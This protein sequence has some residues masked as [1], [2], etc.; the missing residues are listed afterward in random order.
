MDVEV[1]QVDETEIPLEDREG[2]TPTGGRGDV[3][4]T[5]QE[6]LSSVFNATSTDAD[7]ALFISRLRSRL[8]KCFK[9]F[10]VPVAKQRRLRILSEV[11]GIIKP[12]RMTLVLG[13]SGSGK[14]TFLL[15]LSGQLSPCLKVSG[16]VGY[17]GYEFHECEPR[18]NAA[19]VSQQDLHVGEMTVRE[20]FLYSARSQGFG[21][22]SVQMDLLEKENEMGI[23][24]HPEVHKYMEARVAPGVADHLLTGYALKILGLESCA[25][26]L[27]GD[28]VQHG[29]SED[30]KRSVTTGEMLVGP[31]RT[32]FMD[33]TS[34]G[35]DSSTT[36]Q[37]VACFRNLCHSL[38]NTV[39][40]SLLRPSPETFSLFDDII[41]LSEG[42]VL[43]HGDRADVLEFFEDCGFKCPERKPIA[44]FLLE[45]TSPK[46]QEQYWVNKQQLYSYVTATQFREAFWTKSQEG[47]RHAKELETP[48]DKT[49]SHSLALSPSNFPV[50]YNNILKINLAKEWLLMRR[51]FKIYGARF[52]AVTTVAIL[53]STLYFRGKMKREDLQDAQL[54]ASVI[55]CGI[56]TMLLDGYT[57]VVLTVYRLPLFF[58]HR[59][60][61]FLPAWAYTI[62]RAVVN[63]PVSLIQSV[64]WTAI[65]YYT[66]GLAS[67]L[68]R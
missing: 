66:I 17:N 52:T 61:L 1:A 49:K 45:V 6:I 8:D 18:K 48:F 12:G 60:L 25:D 22:A 31:F 40:M 4:E 47:I 30:Q 41:L 3:K 53:A 16:K 37:I 24:P 42:Q 44:E 33:E 68:E 39:V 35:L 29:I 59:D 11:S 7:N 43:F 9:F 15:S 20:T 64:L 62:S 51:N 56:V 14:T 10:R 32:F 36:K 34:S 50:S 21:P 28:S 26:T 65:T 55:F 19:Y 67:A 63:I 38:E 54:Y 27:I 46:D 13:P 5:V 2:N 23:S 57:E 58:K